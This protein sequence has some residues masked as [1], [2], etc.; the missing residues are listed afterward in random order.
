MP[1]GQKVSLLRNL[2]VASNLKYECLFARG[3]RSHLSE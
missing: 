3:G 2:N 1:G